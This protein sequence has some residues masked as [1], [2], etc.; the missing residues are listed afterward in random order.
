MHSTAQGSCGAREGLLGLGDGPEEAAAQQTVRDAQEAYNVGPKEMLADSHQPLTVKEE[1]GIDM[2]SAMSTRRWMNERDPLTFLQTER[3]L[4]GDVISA[5]ER[6]SALLE[7]GNE[8]RDDLPRFV[9]FFRE[10]AA[11]L[12]HKNK[13]A[14]AFA[15]LP[16]LSREARVR[17]KESHRREQA[18]LLSIMHLALAADS[19]DEERRSRLASLLT[20]FCVTQREQLNAEKLNLY[21][22]LRDALAGRDAKNVSR[23]FQESLSSAN[24]AG[25][26]D[27]L[28]SLGEG[29]AEKYANPS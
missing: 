9:A 27:W 2:P 13:E 7:I 6:Y 17:L 21:P 1:A 12:H 3:E 28:R 29:L 26:Y 15:A 16:Q 11:A 4:I 19:H 23:I 25:Q 5:L 18:Q 8:E 14:L 24:F 20:G 10:F 22:A